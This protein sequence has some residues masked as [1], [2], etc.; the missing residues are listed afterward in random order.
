[1]LGSA[2]LRGMQNVD[3]ATDLSAPTTV[4][5]TA[6]HFVGDGGTAWGTS[7]TFIEQQYMLDQGV[8]DADEA[9]LRAVHLPPYETA[10]ENGAMCIM[11]SFSSWGGLKMHAQEHL[12][13]DV[14]KGEMGFRGFLVSDWEAI[15]QL[16]GGYYRD[17]VTSVNAGLDMIMV[18]SNYDAFIDGLT[19]AVDK[20]DVSMERI[21][22]AVRRILTLTTLHG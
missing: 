5:A 12:L 10:I 8:T 11:V 16:P 3:G 9:T 19:A 18:P 22:D 20:G 1:M 21:D 15:D 6:K 14:L 2:Y 13:T 7:E 17:I 4:L